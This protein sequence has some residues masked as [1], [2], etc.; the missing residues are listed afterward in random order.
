MANVIVIDH[1]VKRYAAT[2]ALAI[3]ISRRRVIAPPRGNT[4]TDRA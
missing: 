4:L 1:L 3:T 2:T